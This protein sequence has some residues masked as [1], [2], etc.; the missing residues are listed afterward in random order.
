[1]N[2]IC[3]NAET[4][5]HEACTHES[6]REIPVDA[7]A[8][9]WETT[10]TVD[11]KASCEAAGSKSF[12]CALCDA[13]NTE[14]VTEIAQRTH[15]L[16]DTEVIIEST[17]NTYGTMG[18]KCDHV[19]SDEYVACEYTTSRALTT[20]DPDKHENVVTDEAV[21]P[22]CDDTGLTEGSHC[23]ACGVTVVAQ[24][25]VPA[26]GHTEVIDEAV[27][28]KCNA[29]GLTEGKHCSVCNEVLVEQ[30]VVPMSDHREEEIP[31]VPA[32]CIATGL[33]AGK[34]CKD[35][36]TI[37]LAQEVTDKVAHKEVVDARV[38]PTC[39]GT[40][41][42][43]GKHCS[44]C[45][46]VLVKQDVIEATGH[47]WDK[48]K[49]ESNLTR[50]TATTKGYYTF[51][52]KNDASHTMTEDV[53]RAD[54][55]SYDKVI[56]AVNKLMQEDIPAEDKAKLQ[57]ILDNRLSEGLLDSE[58]EE[59]DIAVDKITEIITEVYPD[60][61]FILEI[62]GATRHYAGTVLNLKAVKVNETVSIDATN[63]QWTS[64]DDSVVFFS[65][66]KLIAIG[67]GTVT[68]TAT[69]GLLTAT[70]TITVV[71]G[72]NVRKVNFTPMANMHFI[73]EDYFAVFNG[74]N[75]NW[76]DDYEIR[77]RVYTYSSFAFE[78]YIVYINGV[79]AV[80]DE[81]GYYTVPANAGEVKVT[82]SGAV[83]ADDGEGSGGTGKFNFWEWLIN[84]FRKIIQF[85]KD[86]F[87][88][89]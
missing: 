54:Y 69:S 52:C 30:E 80:P 60:S 65:N 76:S 2:T 71:E 68:L 57:E 8:H 31:A 47:D 78:T 48:T 24:T 36:G 58:Q 79:E 45:N 12:H 75:L 34:K 25:V 27:E 67:T 26:K 3:Q 89:A 29:T 35:C 44:V 74:A 5:T 22:D 41:L 1:M 84:L 15:N 33:T 86:L 63:V 81:D 19:A 55:S 51:T 10:Y 38:E 61:G 49:D 11:V 40:G 56:D 13:I 53:V 14:S 87:G 72:G 6:T 23:E 62:R 4:D 21:D 28:A 88:V 39:E 32:T 43:E 18:Q 50:P 73:V 77:F 17:C 82:I 20:L 64:S 16:V 66:G 37:T 83:Y 42:T 46:E 59:L 70:K 7:N 9:I 85:F